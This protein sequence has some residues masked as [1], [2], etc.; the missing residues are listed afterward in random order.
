MITDLE[1][2]KEIE[3][4]TRRREQLAQLAALRAEVATLEQRN[5]PALFTRLVTFTA[6]LRGQL[7]AE[8]FSK[9]RDR[10]LAES[11]FIVC[12]VAHLL[13]VR[14]SEIARALQ[15]HRE[16]VAH[17]RRRAAELCAVDAGFA[18]QVAQ[19]IEAISNE[20]NSPND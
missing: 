8:V 17:G 18:A 16:A 11:R 3:W 14:D 9:C 15:F 6:E 2:A 10:A 7:P 20:S 4:L 1:I 13:G 19:V 12:H 5:V